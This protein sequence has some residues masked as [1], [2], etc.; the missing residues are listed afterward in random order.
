[1]FG[2]MV[3]AAR[4]VLGIFYLLSGLNWFFGFLPMLPHIGMP[5]DLPM[6][7]VV[8]SEMIKT[9]WMFQTAKL[10]EIVFGLS[11]LTNR[12][13]PL[14]L[15]A[16]LPVAFITFM[17]DALILDDI[18]RWMTGVDTTGQLLIAIEDMVVGG[19]MVLLPHLW[20]M[21]CYF[22]YYRPAFAWK[23]E[24]T[25]PC[26]GAAA[27]IVT[28]ERAARAPAGGILRTA[29]YIVGGFAILLQAYN[30][31]LISGMIAWR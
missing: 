17:L 23:T 15:A 6:K 2:K 22:S 9:G 30:L 31:Y 18:W 14:M 7:H 13:V 8:V 29:F 25:N 19:L 1:V 24:P 12:A 5:E 4:M 20:L 10:I 3:F 11:M 21:I 27:S 28:V 16:T 26:A